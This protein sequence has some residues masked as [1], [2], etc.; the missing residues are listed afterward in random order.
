[1]RVRLKRRILLCGTAVFLFVLIG[2]VGAAVAAPKIVLSTDR[3]DLGIM[4]QNET[5]E[6]EVMVSNRGDEDLFLSELHSSCPCTVAELG[7]ESLAPGESTTLSIHL[8]SRTFEGDIVKEVIFSTNDPDLPEAEVAMAAFINAPIKVEPSDRTL[9]FGEV[10][11][12]EVSILMAQLRGSGVPAMKA[13]PV[14][15]N[16]DLF[17]VTLARGKEATHQTVRVGVRSDNLTGPFRE[18]LRIETNIPGAETIDLELTGTLGTDLFAEPM[19]VNFRFAKP[20]QALSREV[21]VKAASAEKAF[22]VT[23]AEIDL[24]GLTASVSN[25]GEG[26]EATVLISGA[27]VSK[28][29]PAAKAVRGRFKGKLKITTDNPSQPE[30]LIDVVYLIR[31]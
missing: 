13:K 2:A 7:S 28:D 12:G 1:M 4:N 19:L 9:D 26:G 24:P 21:I 22:K 14:S 10:S 20:G 30:L 25:A 29:D 8:H 3:F 31:M 11:R 6:R 17:V 27:A 15:Y 18:I 23:G 16:E 5:A